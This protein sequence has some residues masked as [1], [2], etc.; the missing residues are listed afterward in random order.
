MNINNLLFTLQARIRNKLL[1]FTH[2][3][4]TNAR[5]PLEL[6]SLINS[7]FTPDNQTEEN[8]VPVLDSDKL[9]GTLFYK[10][11]KTVRDGQ[12]DEF[13]RTTVPETKYET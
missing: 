9:M 4:K 1:I 10:N 12:G 5:P 11:R 3:I 6:R 7:P 8:I 13:G 2:G